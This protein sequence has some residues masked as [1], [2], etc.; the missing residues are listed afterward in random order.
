MNGLTDILE[1]QTEKRVFGLCKVAL[2]Q[3]EALRDYAIQL[4]KIMA[5][6]G[7]EDAEYARA[8]DKFK[9]SRKKIL[10]STNDANRELQDLMKKFTIEL[11][12]Q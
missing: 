5:N 8:D 11:K 9:F 10:D 1:F 6:A 2:E 3:L 7:F 4:E 12:L